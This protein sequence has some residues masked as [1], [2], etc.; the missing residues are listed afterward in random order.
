MSVLNTLLED[1]TSDSFMHETR[2]SS[3]LV[4]TDFVSFGFEM[5][6][7]W[8]FLS[9]PCCCSIL[10][11]TCTFS[12]FVAN[13]CLTSWTLN[14]LEISLC[15]SLIC[16]LL[17]LKISSPYLLNKVQFLLRNWFVYALPFYDL[18]LKAITF[19]GYLS[20]VWFPVMYLTYCSRVFHRKERGSFLLVEKKEVL[21]L[22]TPYAL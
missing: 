21:F 10:L 3:G 18:V 1:W 22:R 7:W 15:F 16:L 6:F 8:I 5:D 12:Q 11:K 4:R 9:G 19:Q 17:P 2:P 13:I 20:V 14:R